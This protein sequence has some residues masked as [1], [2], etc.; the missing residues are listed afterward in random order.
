MEQGDFVLNRTIRL[1]DHVTLKGRGRSTRLI[2]NDQISILAE[3]VNGASICD[4]RLTAGEGSRAA[5]VLDDCG[6]TRIRDSFVAVLQSTASGYGITHFYV[7]SLGA[8]WPGIK[9]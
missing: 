6:N 8:V 7:R 5:I 2:V 3:G 4:V 1:K 9:K